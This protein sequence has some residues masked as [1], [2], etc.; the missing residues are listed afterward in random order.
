MGA[1]QPIS[2]QNEIPQNFPLSPKCFGLSEDDNTFRPLGWRQQ[3]IS[4]LLVERARRY[5]AEDGAGLNTA[6]SVRN[7]VSLYNRA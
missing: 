3:L 7:D 4:Q 6:L 2:A 1:K 5:C